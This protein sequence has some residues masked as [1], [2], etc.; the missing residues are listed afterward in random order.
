MVD[1]ACAQ[2]GYGHRSSTAGSGRV[3][4][5]YAIELS[6]GRFSRNH[7]V[8]EYARTLD[9][10]DMPPRQTKP[11]HGHAWREVSAHMPAEK[12]S[13]YMS[14]QELVE[15]CPMNGAYRAVRVEAQH[16]SGR[17][18]AAVCTAGRCGGIERRFTT[19]EWRRPVKTC[20][21]CS[22]TSR[23]N[24]DTIPKTSGL[25]KLL[26][27]YKNVGGRLMVEALCTGPTCGGKSMR[28]FQSDAWMRGVESCARCLNSKRGEAAE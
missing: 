16:K 13:L 4:R 21:T 25:Y 7:W 1:P 8:I 20:R 9:R 22:A 23:T 6:P 19:S 5:A 12:R 14:A 2:D 11:K 3:Y 17:P 27:V 10:D 18:I 15:L 28:G 26:R 24:A